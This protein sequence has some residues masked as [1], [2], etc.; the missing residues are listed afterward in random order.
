ML[1]VFFIDKSRF[2]KEVLVATNEFRA[3]M[4]KSPFKL[5]KAVRV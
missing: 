5:S 1:F 3:N 2:E 4:N